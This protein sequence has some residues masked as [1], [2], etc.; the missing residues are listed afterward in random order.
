MNPED[1][2]TGE[3]GFKDQQETPGDTMLTKDEILFKVDDKG[4][5]IPEKY[6]ILIYDRELDRELIEESFLLM[7]TIKKQK[8]I[9]GVLVDVKIKQDEEH[10]KLKEQVAKEIDEKKKNKLQLRLNNLENSNNLE[11]I[12]TQINSKVIEAGIIESRATLRS[13]NKIKEEQIVKKFVELMPC[14]TS[15]AYMSFEQGKT[16][17]GKETN[18]W[19]AD[20]ICKK[21]TNPK[22][23]IE[24]AR[25][26][27]MDFKIAIK[28][29]IMSASNYKVKSYRDVITDQK[30]AEDRPLTLKKE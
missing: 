19:V 2:V 7:G 20:L 14:N 22:L 29:A 6:P 10:L 4:I 15:E 26:L 17:D 21:V 23:T 5:A 11:E 3:V 24:E 16:T 13:L 18:D 9:K 27:K 30:L 25:N 8:A 28:E 12:K 1:K